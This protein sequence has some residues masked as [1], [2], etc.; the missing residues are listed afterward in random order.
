MAQDRIG[1]EALPLTQESLAQMLGSRRSSVSVSASTFQK[2]GLIA[3]KHGH[4]TI[5]NRRRLEEA[6][7]DCYAP[8]QRHIKEWQGRDE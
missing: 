4:V 3:Y 8:L 5:M 2:A 6:A 1:S 7:C